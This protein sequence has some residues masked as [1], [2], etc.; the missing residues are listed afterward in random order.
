MARR[1]L[2]NLIST[3]AAMGA[4]LVGESSMIVESLDGPRRRYRSPYYESKPRELSRH[5]HANLAAAE[6]KRARRRAR[7]AQIA[8]ALP[9]TQGS[10]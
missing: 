8:A 1:P 10:T 7:D 6:A 2:L 5:E 9:Q 3:I 4:P